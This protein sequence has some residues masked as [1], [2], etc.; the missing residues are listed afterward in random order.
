MMAWD[1]TYAELA[2]R[3]VLLDLNTLLARD[4]AFAAQLK[5][6]QHRAAL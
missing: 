3:G 2:A 4:Q 6:R 1:L 5:V